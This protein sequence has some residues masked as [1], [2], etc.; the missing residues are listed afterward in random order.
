MG[1][2]VCAATA[3]LVMVK[4]T[5]W[6]PNGTVQDGGTVA[7]AVLLLVSVILRP[8]ASAVLERVTAPVEFADPPTTR[9]GDMASDCSHGLAVK[10]WVLYTPPAVALMV[11]V[12]T[13]GR[14]FAFTLN[15]AAVFVAET[16]ILLGTVAPL[17]GLAVIATD[18]PL[19][20]AGVSIVTVA[21]NVSPPHALLPFKVSPATCIGTTVTDCVFDTPSVVVMVELAFEVM[22][23][24]VTLNVCELDPEGTSTVLGAVAALVLLL[25]SLT[26]AP[27]DGAG[28]DSVTVLTLTWPALIVAAGGVSDATTGASTVSFWLWLV[29]AL[30]AVCYAVAFPQKLMYSATSSSAVYPQ[31][32]EAVRRARPL[33]VR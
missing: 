18:V 10:V 13:F 3:R 28:P 33:R 31:A 8:P 17:E 6:L 23:L 12:S 11:T 32:H 24:P 16:V 15:V 9:A 4:L 25:D 19:E 29:D 30:A 14:F 27:V 26:V 1:T 22:F 7:A 5:C 2:F 21:T 20:G